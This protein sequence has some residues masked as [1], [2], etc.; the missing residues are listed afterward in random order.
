MSKSKRKLLQSYAFSQR[1]VNACYGFHYTSRPT[2][3]V[4]TCL[5]SFLTPDVYS[6]GQPNS[7]PSQVYIT[8]LVPCWN[9]KIHS[10][11]LPTLPLITG[12]GGQTYKIWPWVSTS[13]SFGALWFQEGV[14]YQK[15]KNA[16]EAQ[17]ILTNLK[18][19]SI[20]PLFLSTKF[21]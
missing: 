17:I 7:T 13:V 12:G 2:T 9:G 6:P 5:Q 20:P 19:S 1:C 10:D 14:M 18:I 8:G 3:D 4:A 21:G 11:I 16:L 15:P